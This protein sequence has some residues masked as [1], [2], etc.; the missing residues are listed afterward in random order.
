[1][2]WADRLFSPLW[3]PALAGAIS[4]LL[5]VPAPGQAQQAAP[6][7]N[8]PDEGTASKAIG[9]Q[10]LRISSAELSGG[11][12]HCDVTDTVRTRCEARDRCEVDVNI[13]LCATEALPGLIHVL[14]VHY[15]C[16]TGG[17]TTTATEEEPRSLRLSCGPNRFAPG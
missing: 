2:T 1:M 5:L 6:T 12:H 14:S 3:R 10:A 15:S 17:L 8:A 9:R 11:V 7:Q 4:L 16:R 13:S